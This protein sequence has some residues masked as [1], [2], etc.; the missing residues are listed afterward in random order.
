MLRHAACEAA[1]R[2]QDPATGRDEAWG[3]CVVAGHGAEAARIG[4]AERLRLS[5]LVA[6]RDLG[7]AHRFSV[8]ELRHPHDAAEPAE[9]R[10][11]REVGDLQE[12]HVDVLALPVAA[13]NS[14]G[15]RAAALRPERVGERHPLGR[16]GVLLRLRPHGLALR[17]G[18]ARDEREP[19]VGDVARREHAS[20]LVV[21][22][23]CRDELELVHVGRADRDLARVALRVLAERLEDRAL[24][25]DLDVRPL[26]VGL[27]GEHPI[28][29]KHLTVL[30]F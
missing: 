21:A 26:V 24:D 22:E 10:G 14:E 12:A 1:K 17:L 13:A 18:E 20:D 3:R 15:D 6:H 7:P 16:R 23:G 5:G 29:R 2:D 25:A 9:A 11:D 4:R 8:R 28:A 19:R 27:H 30:V